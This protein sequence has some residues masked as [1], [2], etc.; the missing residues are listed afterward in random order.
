MS[1]CNFYGLL[2]V[3]LVMVPNIFFAA[4][5]PDGFENL[6]QN[7]F[8]ESFEQ[9]GRFGCFACMIFC[10]SYLSAG[11]ASPAQKTLYLVFSAVLV[12]LYCLGWLVF[13]KKDGVAKALVLS[14]LPSVL[15]FE[16]GL[17]LRHT[18]LMV[19]SVVFAV[20]HITLSYKNAAYKQQKGRA[21][22]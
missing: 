14:V 22:R 18:L 10:P 5:H 19:L 17:L 3:A 9:I 4:A 2:W 21:A 16:S 6:Y 8:I 1:W 20:C 13:W 12:A 15:F 11:F 7:K